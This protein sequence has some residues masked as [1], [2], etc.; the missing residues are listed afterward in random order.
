M[1]RVFIENQD[2]KKVVIE[3]KNEN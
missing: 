1:K 3:Y 2:G